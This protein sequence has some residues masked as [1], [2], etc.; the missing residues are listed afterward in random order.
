MK[1]IATV[2]FLGVFLIPFRA[3]AEKQAVVDVSSITACVYEYKGIVQILDPMTQVWVTL[4]SPVPLKEGSRLKTGPGAWCQLLAGDGTFINLY[5]NSE[6]VIETLKLEKDSRDYGFNFIKGR[7][8]WMAAKIKHKIS[9][10]EVRTPSAV[11]AVRGTDFSINVT[12]STT[13]IGIFEGRV[14]ILSGGRETSLTAGSEAVAG[15]ESGVEVS[16]AFSKLMEAEKRRYLKLKKR[17]EELR[18]KLSA[19]EGFIGDFLDLQRKKTQ[20]FEERRQ[21]K[22]DSRAVKRKT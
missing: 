4:T 5:E 8:L 7:I 22:L 10:F 17:A 9:R 11:C 3:S 12:S 2:F 21:K 16:G 13:D 19:R 14:E 6:T 15:S 20:D 1:R 18:T